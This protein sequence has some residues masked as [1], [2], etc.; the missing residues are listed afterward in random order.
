MARID[1]TVGTVKAPKTVL[2]VL[3]TSVKG[4]L[5]VKQG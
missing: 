2:S 3:S 4:L 5:K 1:T